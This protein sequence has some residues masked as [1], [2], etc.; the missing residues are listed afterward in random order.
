M[1]KELAAEKQH[2]SIK[3]H[4]RVHSDSVRQIQYVEANGSIISCSRDRN[5]S[6]A[7]KHFAN[8]RQAYIFKMNRVT[9]LVWKFVTGVL[10]NNH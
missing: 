7:N 5:V 4:G 2:I 1:F 3:T 9:T 6:L 8:R 10:Q